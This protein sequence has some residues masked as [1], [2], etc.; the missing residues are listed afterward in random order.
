MS[1]MQTQ[2]WEVFALRQFLLKKANP[3]FNDEL[4]TR[5]SL[6]TQDWI[7]SGNFFKSI[8]LIKDSVCLGDL[9]GYCDLSDKYE[10]D[11][12]FYPLDGVNPGMPLCLANAYLRDYAYDR[13]TKQGEIK[14]RTKAQLMKLDVLY[15]F[16]NSNKLGIARDA[17]KQYSSVN[18]LFAD[19]HKHQHQR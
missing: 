4:L 11:F 1:A 18:K 12:G 13:I 8:P 2:L 17:A 19:F 6:A 9:P 7:L 3:N 10:L 5:S 14:V 16:Q 15:V